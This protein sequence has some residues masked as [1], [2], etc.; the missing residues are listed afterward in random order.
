MGRDSPGW[1]GEPSRVE[2][3]LGSLV[4][5]SAATFCC[6]ETSDSCTAGGTSPSSGSILL[7]MCAA[8]W[9]RTGAASKPGRFTF[10]DPPGIPKP[11]QIH[12]RTPARDRQAQ[13]TNE[14]PIEMS[15]QNR[16]RIHA[17]LQGV[18]AYANKPPTNSATLR[19]DELT[20]SVPVAVNSHQ[21]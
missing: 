8:S 1:P 15:P 16:R 19:T 13:T 10:A 6:R 4:A 11:D 20:D 14:P 7:G 9:T 21:R 5:V 3:R 18:H 17:I 12:R 2:W